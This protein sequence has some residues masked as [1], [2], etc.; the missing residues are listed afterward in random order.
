M[1]A[2]KYPQPLQILV[3]DTATYNHY[4]QGNRVIHNGLPTV[5]KLPANT[6]Q[7]SPSLIST[8]KGKFINFL[9]FENK[10]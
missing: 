9:L 8:Q 2:I 7:T 5:Q 10:V 4:K 1:H 3:A 6:V